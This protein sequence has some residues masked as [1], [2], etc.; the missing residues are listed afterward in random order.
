MGND[1][2]LSD[3]TYKTIKA[4][5]Q[6]YFMDKRSKFY[7]YAYPVVSEDEIKE[8]VAGLKKEYYDARHHVFAW[9]LGKDKEHYRANDDGEP[10]GSSAKPIYGQ[11]LSNDLTNI[12]IVVIRYFG[13]VKLGVP[14]LINAYKTAAI[15]AINNAEIITKIVEDVYVV[16][17]DYLQ[18]NEI[19]KV[20]KKESLDIINQKFDNQCEIQFK[21]R[22]TD[23]ERLKNI[24]ENIEFVQIDYLNTI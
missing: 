16:R 18:M 15:D 20:V 13:G 11:L 10:S 19:M 9:I 8:I 14:G 6:G 23:S 21:I 1:P 3:D 22:K 4:P 12:L 24:F 5:S 7:A 2:N 17:F